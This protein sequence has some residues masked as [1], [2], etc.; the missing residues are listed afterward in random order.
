MNLG[1]LMM[2]LRRPSEG[3]AHYE[4]AVSLIP[5]S[6]DAQMR[7]GEAYFRENRFSEANARFE[8]ALS[9]ARS[10]GQSEAV[11]QMLERIKTCEG[12][13]GRKAR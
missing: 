9:I 12:R 2:E 10:N 6:L 4:Q 5:E 3:L 13:L 7:L 1:D 11:Q 8:F